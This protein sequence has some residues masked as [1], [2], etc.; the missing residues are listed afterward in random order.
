MRSFF[1]LAFYWSFSFF[2]SGALLMAGEIILKVKVAE[3]GSGEP[4]IGASVII[5]GKNGGAATDLEGAAQLSLYKGPANIIISY[6]GYQPDTLQMDLSKDTTIQVMLAEISNQLGVIEVS[7]T[8]VKRNNG[9][10]GVNPEILETLPTFFGE[11]ELVKAL[12]L[13]P[14]VQSG[15]EGSN[16]I[17]VRGGSSDQN[18][19][20]L[21]GVPVYNLSHLYGIL[22]V[23][24]SDVVRS[25]DLYKN[26]LPPSI[27]GRLTSAIA[28]QSKVPSLTET[29]FGV[30]VGA[31]STK[32]FLQTPIIKNKLS[33]QIALRGCHAGIVIKPASKTQFDGPGE[34][35][36]MS[37]YFYDI[38]TGLNYKINDRQSLRWNFFFTDDRYR[39]SDAEQGRGQRTI[40]GITGLDYDRSSNLYLSWKNITTSFQHN[41]ELR[42][43][44]HLS[45]QL[46]LSQYILGQRNVRLRNYSLQG[47]LLVSQETTNRKKAS[48]I[49]SG[50]KGTFNWNKRKHSLKWGYQLAMRNLQPDYTD[51]KIITNRDLTDEQRFG[52]QYIPTYDLDTYAEY[53]YKSSWVN[54]YTGAR[55]N[56]YLAE[57]Y[58]KLAVLPRL[59][60]EFNLP[61]YVTIQLASNKTQQNV[62][63]INS[64]MGDIMNDFWVPANRVAPSETAIQNSF[65][66]R[67]DIKGYF[68]SVDVYH[69]MARNQIEFVQR[70]LYE[71]KLAWEQD[72]LGG[73]QGRAYG[74]E[75]Y[76]SRT[77]DKFFFSANYNL[78]R[79]ER[80]F[81]RLNRGN[82]YPYLYDRTH[83]ASIAASYKLKN[84]FEFTVAWV[85]G[86]GKTY[87]MPAAV[88]PSLELVDYYGQL[89]VDRPPLDHKSD[90]IEYFRSRNNHRL[91]A[92]HHLDIG[93]NYKWKKNK[94]EH[95]LNVSCYN[96]YNRMNVFS[97]M[98]K[99][100][101]DTEHPRTIYRSITLMP[102]LPSFSYAV[103][104]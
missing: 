53:A 5:P 51:Y 69:R 70:S 48:V 95:V 102:F 98:T 7:A 97:L 59:S 8:A 84:R 46:Y 76:V 21:D 71:E 14:G 20:T 31:I 4:L 92:F 41:V 40:E 27:G 17:F 66:V 104:F 19:V 58:R 90:Q 42:S 16:A 24:N 83:D 67:Q 35:G 85:Y 61:K 100:Y 94:W 47:T 25:A 91:K 34:D 26:Y 60:I 11:R 72:V 38:N 9:V 68:W 64:S 99:T 54:V 56:A 55:F 63:M 79:S 29:H 45:Q 82:W 23:F 49:E 86:T 2:C 81:D 13:L 32:V 37:Y 28:V 36:F 78:S 39:L 10:M 88:Y 75:F 80:R 73:G 93:F 43:G 1:L 101:D 30:Q 44:I 50:L 18:L 74:V 22:S 33:T 52:D 57:G 103:S 12:Q 15:S 89:D 6:I 96:V 87:T 77:L 3:M 62:H 65:S